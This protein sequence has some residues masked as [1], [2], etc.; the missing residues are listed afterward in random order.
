MN[1]WSEEEKQYLEENW[2]KYSISNIT[3]KLNRTVNGV[4]LKAE[5]G[6]NGR[7]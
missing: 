5:N 1:K 3:N 2:G 4:K 6:V 7:V